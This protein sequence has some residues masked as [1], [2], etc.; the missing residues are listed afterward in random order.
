VIDA[1]RADL[2]VQSFDVE[3]VRQFVQAA[4]G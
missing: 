1:D 4:R 3:R 2:D